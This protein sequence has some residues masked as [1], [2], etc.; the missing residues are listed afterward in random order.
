MSERLRIV[1]T[2]LAVTFP[3]GGVFWD[4][5]QYALGFQQLGHDVLY[6]EDTGGSWCYDATRQTFVEAGAANA[7]RFE[8]VVAALTPA[9]TGRWFFR[10][11][12]QATYGMTWETVAEFCRTADLFVHVSASCRLRD[13]YR[14]AR[15]LVF[16]DSD[17]MYTQAS[18]PRYA[19]GAT[20]GDERDRVAMLLQH[21]RFFTFAENVGAADCR[22]PQGLISWQPTRQPIVLDRFAPLTTPP[23]HRRRVL[24]TVASWET[25]EAAPVIDGVT[26]GGKSQEF[27]RFLDLPARSPLPLELA[28]SGPAPRERLA[29]HG[30]HV[31]D[32]HAVSRDPA[33]YR[34]YLA[35]SFAEWS[36]AKNA[37]VASRSGWF[38]CRSAC[39]LALGVPV[40]VQDTGFRTALRAGE[41]LL[42]FATMD[43][44]ADAIERVVSDPLRH[45]R[46]AAAMAREHFDART[47][48]GN[49]IERSLS[50]AAP[51]G[52]TARV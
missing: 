7:A 24:T 2:G 51:T 17:P 16:V 37:Y 21:D 39:Y 1:V 43:E 27:E 9:I 15:R 4:Y 34:D 42:A 11:A 31:V 29:R 50:T 36:V 30:W 47:V 52:A 5:L 13:E 25:S 32:G 3:L 45:A 22:V 26:Y 41:G 8:D 19:A 6:L 23:E 46:A 28:L 20:T 14:R 10:D 18:F 35:R 40:I 48:L 49:L 38:S 44:A 12:R 33:T